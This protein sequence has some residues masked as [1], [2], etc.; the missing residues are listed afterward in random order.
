MLLRADT[1]G[2]DGLL[3]S[4]PKIAWNSYCFLHQVVH[5]NRGIALHPV[6]IRWMIGAE[7]SLSSAASST[8]SRVRHFSSY[9]CT[10]NG[11]KQWHKKRRR[12]ILQPGC[13][14]QTWPASGPD[15]THEKEGAGK[16]ASLPAPSACSISPPVGLGQVD[17]IGWV[18]QRPDCGQGD[19]CDAATDGHRALEG[20]ALPE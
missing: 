1:R 13:S 19:G 7:L 16:D 11:G 10:R 12:C 6:H 15:H 5:Q 9:G 2:V 8:P 14:N 17:R 18:S 4:V 3:K 20:P